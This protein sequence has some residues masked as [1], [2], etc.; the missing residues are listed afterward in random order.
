MSQHAPG[1][2]GQ[3]CLS[4]GNREWRNGK[5][6]KFVGVEMARASMVPPQINN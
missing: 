6:Q 2:A 5:R 3:N 4:R 1:L